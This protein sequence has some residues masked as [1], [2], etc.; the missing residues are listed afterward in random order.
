MNT[1]SSVSLA[2]RLALFPVLQ[3]T[4][5]IEEQCLNTGTFL[6]ILRRHILEIFAKTRRESSR[7]RKIV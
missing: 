4:V 7:F 3:V 5:S 6:T 2:E 1:R